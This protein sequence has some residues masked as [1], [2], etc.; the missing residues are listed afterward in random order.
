M[1]PVAIAELSGQA[2]ALGPIELLQLMAVISLQ[3]ALLNL[4]PVPVL[5]GGQIAILA[6]EGVA[7]RDMSVRVKEY[8]AMAGAALIVLLMVTVLYNDIARMIR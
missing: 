3:L 6:L 1:G 8:F 5:D 2:A 7:R 4:M